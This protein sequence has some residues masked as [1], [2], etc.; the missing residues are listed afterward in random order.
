MVEIYFIV[1]SNC[2]HLTV[3]SNLKQAIAR[4]SSPLRTGPGDIFV[5]ILNVAG[6]AVQAVGRIQFQPALTGVFVDFNFIDIARAKPGTGAA[7][8]GVADVHAKVGIVYDE[9]GGL[10]FPMFGL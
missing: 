2:C 3:V 5:G 9:M 4:P 1:S 6:F 8:G 10:I 7:V